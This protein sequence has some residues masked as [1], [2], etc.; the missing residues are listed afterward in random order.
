MLTTLEVFVLLLPGHI[1][2][3]EFGGCRDTSILATLEVA[4]QTNPNKFGGV[5]PFGRL[6]F[7]FAPA[8]FALAVLHNFR[9]L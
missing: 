9:I 7:H 2:P 5:S 8:H 4:G 6:R 3:G 1:N